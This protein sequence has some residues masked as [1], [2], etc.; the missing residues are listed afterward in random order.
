MLN[1]NFSSS[2]VVRKSV[3]AVRGGVVAAQHRRAAEAGAAVLEAGGDAMDAAVATSFAIG[4]VEPW[5]SGPAAGGVMVAWRA[6]EAKAYAIDYG[7]RAPRALDPADYPLAA[8]S[9]RAADLFAWPLVEG[10]RNVQGASAVAVPG[11][12]AGMALAHERFGRMP[13]RELLAPAV[14]LARRGLLLDWYSSLLIASTA[15]ALSLDRDAAALFLEDGQWAPIGAWTALTEKRLD[16][17]KLAATLL[18]I[19]SD[20]NDFYKGEIAHA[21][22][23]D[24]RDK[25]G[26]L[27]LEDLAAYRA[28]IVDA[29]EVPYRGGRVLAAPGMTGGPTLARAFG[30]LSGIFKPEPGRPG[31]GSYVA[32]ARALESA[33]RSRF[34]EMGDRE[35]QSAPACTTHF[36]VVDRH[37]NQCAVT[38]T[39]LSI[40][41]ARVVSP[42][43][44]VLL[45]N[46]IMWFDPEPG[47]PNSLGPGKRCL[48]NYCPVVGEASDGRRFA[49]GASGGRKIIGSV[50]QISS[51]MMDHGLSLEEA[52]HQPRIDMSGGDKV[53]A[54][55][56]LPADVLRAL[57]SAFPTATA[58]RMVFPYAFAV[59]AA[60]LRAGEL[61]MGCTEVMSPWGDAVAEKG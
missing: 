14:A 32:Y 27:S 58:R 6:Q 25:G 55:A 3:V 57:E 41:G 60:V 24:V 54:D 47:K 39:L 46:G 4:V 1:D 20:K 7:M 18:C 40:F 42:S 61:N 22:V 15:R 21:V 8:G 10:D 5:M 34:A 44:G 36:S 31:A 33:W 48:G 49:L 29:L 16:Q 45:N 53:I 59:P 51:F 37:G 26:C 35:A 17:S 52:F 2:Q 19:G 28:H 50:L 9:G 13:W 30:V 56:A 11:V 23:E 43:T 38:Q 12:V